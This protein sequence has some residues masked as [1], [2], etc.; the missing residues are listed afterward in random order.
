LYE[1]HGRGLMWTKSG[2]AHVKPGWNTYEILAVG[3]KIRTSINGQPC[4]DLE[5]IGGARRGIMA[6]QLIPA[7]SPK[8][9]TRISSSN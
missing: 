4:A 8:C 1:E 2:E 7:D 3:S 5:D 9:A 6:L